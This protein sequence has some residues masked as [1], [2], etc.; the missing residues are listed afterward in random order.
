MACTENGYLLFYVSNENTYTVFFDNLQVV[1]KPGSIVKETHYYP[2]GLTMAGISSKALNG[3]VQ[4]R[5]K[6]IGGNELQ[7]G[8]FTD[9][10][11]LE[12]FDAVNRSYDPQLGRFWQIDELADANWEW[13]PYNISFN[14]PIRFNDPLGLKE[15]PNDVKTLPELVVTAKKKLSHNE[16]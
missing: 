3:A 12:L 15:G 14:N 6:F 13:A 1:H 16:I 9:G 10:A 8:E 2:F 7:S 5:N 4:N 11:G